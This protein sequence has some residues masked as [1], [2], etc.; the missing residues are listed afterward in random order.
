MARLVVATAAI[1][2]ISYQF[3]TLRSQVP[4]FSPANFFSFFTIH[5]NLFAI[6]MLGLVVIRPVRPS[7]APRSTRFAGR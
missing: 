3:A 6:A 5:P 1:V 7:G 4:S 2:A